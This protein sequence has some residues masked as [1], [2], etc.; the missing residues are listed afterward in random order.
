MFLHVAKC[1]RGV[2]VTKVEAVR[3]FAADASARAR[4]D[5]FLGN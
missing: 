1:F 2:F 3:N 5:Q 4:G